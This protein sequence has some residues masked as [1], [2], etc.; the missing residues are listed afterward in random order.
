MRILIH[1][2]ILQHAARG[3]KS[4]RVSGLSGRLRARLSRS[5]ISGIDHRMTRRRQMD[6]TAVSVRGGKYYLDRMVDRQGTSVNHLLCA[7]RSRDAA[8]AFIRKA[9][10]NDTA[11]PRTVNL[12]SNLA[13][14]LALRMLG[15]KDPTWQRVVVR[16]HRYLNYVIEQ[17]HRAIKSRCVSM[18]GFKSFGTARPAGKRGSFAEFPAGFAAY[19]PA[20][21]GAVSTWPHVFSTASS[22]PIDSQVAALRVGR[23]AANLSDSSARRQS[24]QAEPRGSH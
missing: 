21:T 11:W 5:A 9:V 14:H 15:E 24:R 20:T 2:T 7:G 10:D 8:E 12:D 6:E 22:S 1:Q 16:D 4:S 17:D 13:S 18:L 23:A 3:R 19:P